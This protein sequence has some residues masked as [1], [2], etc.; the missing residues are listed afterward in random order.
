MAG[1]RNVHLSTET[2]ESRALLAFVAHLT[3]NFAQLPGDR[4][5]AVIKIKFTDHATQA[6][7]SG[8]LK[9]ISNPSAVV[10]RLQ[11]NNPT[12][13]AAVVTTTTT[14]TQTTPPSAPVTATVSTVTTTTPALT[15]A[16]LLKPGNGS[17]PYRH[18]RFSGTINAS[19]LIG[20]LTGQPLKQL[21][22]DMSEGMVSAVVTTNNGVDAATTVAPGNAKGGEIKGTFLATGPKPWLNNLV[23]SVTQ[24]VTASLANK[25]S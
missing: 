25:S 12:M 14:T 5:S 15:V 8:T 19:S 23:Q 17:G 24:A 10:L 4:A 22:T 13:S 1:K 6:V 7:V 20:D 18:V 2:L 9:D 3:P 21:Q 11:N 16:V